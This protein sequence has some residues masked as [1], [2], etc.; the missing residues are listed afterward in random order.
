MRYLLFIR[1]LTIFVRRR[2]ADLRVFRLASSG[3]ANVIFVTDIY[4]GL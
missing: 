2:S 3:T 4:V 1:Q